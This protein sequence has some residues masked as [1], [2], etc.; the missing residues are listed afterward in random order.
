MNSKE[1][2]QLRKKANPLQHTVIIGKEGLTDNVILST[3]RE[4]SARELV[5]ISILD[6]EVDRK[7]IAEEMARRLNAE[8]VCIIG[9]K[10]VFYRFSNKKGVKHVLEIE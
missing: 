4:L 6:G 2:A 5:K 9:K 7:V 10:I 1:R 3:D 8:C